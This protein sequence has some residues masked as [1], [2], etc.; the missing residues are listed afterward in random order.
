MLGGRE[1]TLELKQNSWALGRLLGAWASVVR[2]VRENKTWLAA[3]ALDQGSA[4]VL[5]L[6]C[7]KTRVF[8]RENHSNMPHKHEMHLDTWGHGLRVYPQHNNTQIRKEKSRQ[9][10]A[11]LGVSNTG[12]TSALA[13]KTTYSSS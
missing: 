6:F 9:S 4:V 3:R 13:R 11:Q 8:V 2:L 12:A 1:E 5:N 10:S 7:L